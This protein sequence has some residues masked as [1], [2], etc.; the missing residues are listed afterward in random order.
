MGFQQLPDLWYVNKLIKGVFGHAFS[1]HV[2]WPTA[3]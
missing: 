1:W 2:A 3:L